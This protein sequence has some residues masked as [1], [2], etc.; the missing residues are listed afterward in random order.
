MALLPDLVRDSKLEV[1][2][3]PD[4]VVHTFY[5]SDP[6]SYQQEVTRSEHWRREKQIGAGSFG[7][8][9][10]ERCTDGGHGSKVRAVKQIRTSLGWTRSINC[11]DEL[12]A[13]AKFSHRKVCYTSN[14]SYRRWITVLG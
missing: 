14:S 10:L 5:E 12:E 11:T 1:S 2:F 8:I 6:S 7:S 9:W 13:I 4:C 3:F